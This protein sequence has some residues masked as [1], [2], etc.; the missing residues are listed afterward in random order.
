MVGYAVHR[1]HERIGD[2]DD[3]LVDDASWTIRYMVVDVQ[4]WWPDKKV[5]VLPRSVLGIAWEEKAV[6][7]DLS[8]A[9]LRNAPGYDPRRPIDRDDE[10]RLQDYYDRSKHPE[11]GPAQRG[12]LR[13]GM[14]SKRL[15]A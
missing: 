5:L 8:R 10:T 1:I 13:S 11:D 6:H 12:G 9:T 2:V 14:E 3:F 15:E 7:V 4:G